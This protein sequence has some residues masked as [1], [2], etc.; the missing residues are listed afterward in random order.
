MNL[1]S[2]KYRLS[3]NKDLYKVQM[4]TVAWRPDVMRLEPSLGL[5]LLV[6]VT[7]APGAGPKCLK[8]TQRTGARA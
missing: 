5:H 2:Y 8:A 1:S 3:N 6:S 7:A 4:N